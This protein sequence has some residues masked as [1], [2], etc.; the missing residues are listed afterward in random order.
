MCAHL[1]ANS[2]PLDARRI[3]KCIC[4]LHRWKL[5]KGRNLNIHTHLYHGAIPRVSKILDPVLV[6]PPGHYF[7]LIRSNL[8]KDWWGRKS[9]SE[10]NRWLREAFPKD[11]WSSRKLSFLSSRGKLSTG[12]TGKLGTLADL[13]AGFVLVGTQFPSPFSPP[14]SSFLL[15]FPCQT[16]Y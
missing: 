16:A 14:V 13:H 9:W 15:T 3:R 1:P 6:L 7:R 4:N 12:E 8:R 5:E 10:I 2:Y 11:G